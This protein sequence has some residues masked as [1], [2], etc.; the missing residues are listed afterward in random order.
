MLLA[1][2]IERCKVDV[3]KL[4]IPQDK[5]LL[6]S[7]LVSIRWGDMDTMGHVNNAMYFRYMESARIE[8]MSNAGFGTNPTGVGFVIAN[9]FCNFIRQLEYPGDVVVK[10]FVGH[11]GRSSFDL[12]HELLRADTGEQIFANGGA[13]MVWLDFPKQQPL[14]LPTAL[15]SW[16]TAN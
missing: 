13:T 1:F 12:Y 14:P 6:G 7:M 16:L 5:R 3:M 4:E 8:L 10:T 2:A 11:V 15:R 9:V